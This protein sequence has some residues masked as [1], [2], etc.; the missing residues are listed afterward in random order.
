MIDRSPEPVRICSSDNFCA[1][2]DLLIHL[3]SVEVEE[4]TFTRTRAVGGSS[5]LVVATYPSCAC[6][7]LHPQCSGFLRR[8]AAH[9]SCSIRRTASPRP[10]LCPS[11]STVAR[12]ISHNWLKSHFIFDTSPD[13]LVSWLTRQYLFKTANSSWSS[14]RTLLPPLCDVLAL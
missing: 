8:H 6:L 4:L 13:D 7:H 9:L 3:L 14:V 11:N 10:T 5:P 1:L 2:P 12:L